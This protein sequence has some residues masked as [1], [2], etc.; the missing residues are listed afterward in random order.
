MT[1]EQKRLDCEYHRVV[2]AK[3]E[4][5]LKICEYEDQIVRLKDHVKVQEARELELKN[6]I[7]EVN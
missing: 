4:L 6:K 3:K 5:E 2:A 7:K 1:L